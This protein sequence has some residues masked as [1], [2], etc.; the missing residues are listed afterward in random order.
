MLW[1][2]QAKGRHGERVAR[3]YLRRRGFRIL[4]ANYRI[5]GGEID[6][7]VQDG[8]TVVFVEVKA[9]FGNRFGDPGE[10]VSPAKQRRIIRAARCYIQRARLHDHNMRFDVVT[11][12]TRGKISHVRDA[13]AVTTPFLL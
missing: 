10:W 6:L 12:N 9:A 11:L 8:E 13:F 7:I 4:E 3:R 1:S 5:R 2:V